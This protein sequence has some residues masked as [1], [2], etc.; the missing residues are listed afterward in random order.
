MSAVYE[1]WASRLGH[2]NIRIELTEAAQPELFC[3][4]REVVTDLEKSK[5]VLRTL[6]RELGEEA[7]IFLSRAAYSKDPGKADAIYKTIVYGLH[8]SKKHKIMNCM[9]LDCVCMVRKL[10]LNVWHEAHRLMGFLRFSELADGILFA[11]IHPENDILPIIAPHFA[12]RFPEE[13]WVICD[14]NR[15]RFAIHRAQKG[16]MLLEGVALSPETKIHFSE[17]EDSYQQLWKTFVHHIA[18]EGRKNE[19]LQNSLLPLKFRDRMTECMNT[20]PQQR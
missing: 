5:K 19:M 11:G 4:Y 20:E 2:Q 17:Q 8:L 14:E 10:Q 12:D 13:N 1:G 15:D 16:W 7:Y 3:D 18:I 9:T 6:R